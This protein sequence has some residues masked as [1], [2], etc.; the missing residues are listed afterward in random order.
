M[1]TPITGLDRM[2]RKLIVAALRVQVALCDVFDCRA[3]RLRQ[4][5][6]QRLEGEP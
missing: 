4:E 2:E 5:L 3:C 1:T 6:I